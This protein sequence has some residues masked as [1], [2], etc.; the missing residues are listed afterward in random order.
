MSH[1]DLDKLNR[2][3]LGKK[4]Q[5]NRTLRKKK[6]SRSD[7]GVT[8]VLDTKLTKPIMLP[9]SNNSKSVSHDTDL[10]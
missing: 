8:P 1:I 9:E 7:C 3:G 6:F 4:S 5:W 10:L 2:L